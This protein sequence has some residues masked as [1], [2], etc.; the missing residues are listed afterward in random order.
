MFSL[1][2]IP[3]MFGFWPKLMVFNAA[4]AEG[5]YAAGGGR[6]PRHG[7]GRLLLP[8]IVKVMYFDAPGAA[9]RQGAE[10]RSKAR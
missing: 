6:H 7:G 5:L 3:P 2:G 4:V 1:A 10:Q 8:E 9:L